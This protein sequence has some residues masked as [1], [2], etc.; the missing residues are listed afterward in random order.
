MYYRIVG[1]NIDLMIHARIQNS[2]T[3]NRSLH[4][5]QQYAVVNRVAMSPLLDSNSPRK[6]MQN[7]DLLDLL[8]TKAVQDNLINRWACLVSRV[9]C[10]YLE[11][12]KMWWYATFHI[13][14]HEP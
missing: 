10:K 12:F 3:P 11:K 14:T 9:V 5:T 1:D 8:P 6:P 7:V 13:L 2:E 4:W